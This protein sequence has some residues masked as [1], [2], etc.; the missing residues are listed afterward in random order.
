MQAPSRVM[1]N[2]RKNELRQKPTDEELAQ[3]VGM[4]DLH[5]ESGL[6]AIKRCGL[7]D[8]FAALTGE[9]SEADIVSD[10]DG[11]ILWADQ[12]ELS[13]RPE[14]SRN[15]LHKLLI[16]NLPAGTIKWGHKLLS[17][18][19]SNTAGRTETEL[20]FGPHGKQTFDLAVGADGTWSRVR[21]LLTDVRPQYSGM[22]NINVTIRQ[23]TNKYPELAKLIGPGSFMALGTKHGVM[24]H[25]TSQ[26][27]AR[28]Y[29]MLTTGDQ[30]FAKNSGLANMT[31]A[32]A[33][34]LILN[35]DA[36]LGRWGATLK[37]LVSI[38]C[39]EESAANPGAI[40]DVKPLCV[41]PPGRSW[42]HKPGVT[43]IGDAAHVMCP[44]AGE[45]VNLA[46]WDSLLL[47]EA[48]IKAYEAAGHNATSFQIALAPLIKE[49]ELDMWARAKEKAEETVSNGEMMFGGDDG[50]QAMAG[51]FRGAYQ[52]IEEM[53]P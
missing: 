34:D 13:T 27:S 41:L 40:I 24:S 33:K 36:L 49:F 3:P 8:Q 15:A 53:Q 2:R 44:W 9:C 28:I 42:D 48:I 35:D 5:E 29:L 30:D 1:P 32:Q 17:A 43:L 25:R 14:I 46:L 51:L 38:A 11:N 52:Q 4:L 23:I 50:A 26:D 20:D 16:D 22:Q 10:K 39:D 21:P 7:Y 47:S 31:A 12:G 37:E 45:G 18:T 19:S 6:A